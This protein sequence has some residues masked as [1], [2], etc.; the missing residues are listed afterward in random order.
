M[1]VPYVPLRSQKWW[2][3]RRQ[4]RERVRIEC[5]KVICSSSQLLI[6]IFL[7]FLL[8]YM[9][10]A[11][12]MNERGINVTIKQKAI[13]STYRNDRSFISWVKNHLLARTRGSLG[14]VCKKRW[15]I[16]LFKKMHTLNFKLNI[17][18]VNFKFFS[19]S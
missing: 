15:K 13:K 9:L 5:G 2:W 10:A 14:N 4:R 11:N 12:A 6:K 3:W 19:H 17:F 1:Q 7:T 8:L 18:E 16:I